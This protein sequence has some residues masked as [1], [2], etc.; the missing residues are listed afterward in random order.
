MAMGYRLGFKDALKIVSGTCLD[1][2]LNEE[3]L[4]SQFQKMNLQE[5]QSEPEEGVAA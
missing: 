3:G 1:Q 4:V 5:P 2:Q